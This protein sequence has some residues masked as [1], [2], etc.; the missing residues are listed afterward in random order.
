MV[1]NQKEEIAS[2]ILKVPGKNNKRA[3]RRYLTDRGQDIKSLEAPSKN[4]IED[5]LRQIREASPVQKSHE[6]KHGRH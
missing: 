3:I 5:I 2:D 1:E 6:K 4:E